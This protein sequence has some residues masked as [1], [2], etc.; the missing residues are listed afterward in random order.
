MV[1]PFARSADI[2]SE[3]DLALS[4]HWLGCFQNAGPFGLI[5]VDR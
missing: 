3:D 1:R 2:R 4:T 5:R